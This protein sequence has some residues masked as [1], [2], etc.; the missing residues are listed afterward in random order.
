M[1][2]ASPAAPS[3]APMSP[4]IL[5]AH[6][7]AAEVSL[8]LLQGCCIPDSRILMCHAWHECC[9]AYD[10]IGCSMLLPNHRGPILSTHA[11]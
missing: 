8:L 6:E 2:M 9:R 11:T 3:P 7:Q 1:G 5:G 4:E 10:L